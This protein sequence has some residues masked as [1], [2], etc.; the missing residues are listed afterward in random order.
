MP[1]NTSLID[2]AY[3]KRLRSVLD[4]FNLDSQNYPSQYQNNG[5]DTTEW[6]NDQELVP[7]P[8]PPYPPRRGP[9]Y[10]KMKN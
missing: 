2:E 10:N 7:G 3:E 8:N 1:H 5:K 4:L 6:I 9:K